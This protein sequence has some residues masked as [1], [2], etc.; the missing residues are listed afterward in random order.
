[1]CRARYS[2]FS[3]VI[4]ATQCTSFPILVLICLHFF[5]VKTRLN[6]AHTHEKQTKKAGPTHRAHCPSLR[7]KESGAQSS[8]TES[9][10]GSRLGRGS[11]SGDSP[12]HSEG[13]RAPSRARQC[14][15]SVTRTRPAVPAPPWGH[16]LPAPGPETGRGAGH[17]PEPDPHPRS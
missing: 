15:G 6:S 8:G 7:T 14:R 4:L 11:S 16:F 17:H 10:V 5:V 9:G 3:Q 13:L 1:M 2:L 12:G